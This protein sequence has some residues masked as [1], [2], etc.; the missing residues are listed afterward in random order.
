MVLRQTP[1][2]TRMQRFRTRILPHQ[3]GQYGKF[4]SRCLADI[5]GGWRDTR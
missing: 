2:Y 5:A 3:P 1:L 4:S